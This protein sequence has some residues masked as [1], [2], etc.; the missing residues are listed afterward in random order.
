MRG[1]RKQAR[2]TASLQES[3]R[4]PLIELEHTFAGE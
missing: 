4:E 2:C 1:Y 3:V